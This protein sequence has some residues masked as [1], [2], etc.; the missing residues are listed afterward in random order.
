MFSGGVGEYIYGTESQN[1]GDLGNL[2]GKKIMARAQKPAFFA[3][4]A[5]SEEKIRATVI[6]ASQYTIQVSGNTIF[7][8][9]DQLLP[10]RNLKVIFPRAGDPTG[11]ISP[12]NVEITIRQA[13]ERY[14]LTEGNEPV[15]LAFHWTT[16]PRYELLRSFAEGIA[17][18]LKKTIEKKMPVV[19]IFNSDIGKSIGRIIHT[20]M[21]IGSEVISLDQVHLHEFDFIDIGEVVKMVDAVPVVVKSLVFGMDAEEALRER[22]RKRL[23]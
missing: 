4:V 16:E 20:E 21:Q 12:K 14:D 19:L 11:E 10:L 22:Q 5:R 7:V 6:G 18:A 23:H 3:P 13:F 9:D 2:L 8:S 1:F 15:A 17:A